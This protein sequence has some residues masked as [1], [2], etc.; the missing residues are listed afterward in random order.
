MTHIRELRDLERYLDTLQIHGLGGTDFRPV[1]A[2]VDSE[3]EQGNLT[4]L[5]GVIYFT[6]GHGTFPKHRPAYDTAFV[7]ME[8]PE[9]ITVPPWAMKVVLEEEAILQE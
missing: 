3:L 4:N 9:D 1:F 7:L 8:D 5:A 2:Y 6:D